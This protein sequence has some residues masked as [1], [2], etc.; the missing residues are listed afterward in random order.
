MTHTKVFSFLGLA[1]RAR[2]VSSGEELVV[3]DVR[4]G[5]AKLVFLSNDAS[6]NTTKK[7][8]D[9]CHSYGVRCIVIGDR[10]QLGAAIGKE[11]RVVVA[12]TDVGFAKKLTEL[13]NEVTK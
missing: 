4:S 1:Y 7:I 9:K 6:S 8:T 2:K 5:R 11:A 10:Y 12:I 13:V 3:G